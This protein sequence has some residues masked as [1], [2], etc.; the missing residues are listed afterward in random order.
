LDDNVYDYLLDISLR[1]TPVQKALRDETDNLEWARMQISPDQAQFMALLVRLINARKAIEVG[2]FTGYSALS[3][4]QAMPDDGVVV[5][6]DISEEWTSI[7]R[8]FWQQ[9]GVAHKIELHVAP[10]AETLSSL[11]EDGQSGTYDFAFIDADKVNQLTYYELCMQLIHPGGLIAVDNVLWGGDVADPANH[12]EDTEA[13]R[14]F[15][16]FIYQDARVDISLVPIGDGLTLA[17]KKE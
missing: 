17:R 2:T 9:A 12:N 10:A 1:D 3:V 7:G 11:I 14:T 13:I 5:A 16:Q 6:C 8:R 4:A 15:N